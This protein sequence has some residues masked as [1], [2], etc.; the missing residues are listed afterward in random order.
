ML[1]THQPLDSLKQSHSFSVP[2]PNLCPLPVV[3][4]DVEVTAGGEHSAG[5]AASTTSFTLMLP[6]EL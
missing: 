3:S 5:N 6:S 2:V 4:G 1:K